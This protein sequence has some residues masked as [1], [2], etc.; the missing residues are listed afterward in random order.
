MGAE[1]ASS[2]V[3]TY[4]IDKDQVT[5]HIGKAIY[6]VR[7]TWRAGGEALEFNQDVI[8]TYSGTAAYGRASTSHSTRPAS[9][10][11]PMAPAPQ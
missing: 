6:F 9:A 5:L 11:S 8:L 7:L 4:E 1:S 10:V 2:G 3:G